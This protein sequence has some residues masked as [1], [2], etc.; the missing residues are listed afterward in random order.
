MF[1]YCTI[2]AFKCGT[3]V[4]IISDSKPSA[5]H[6]VIELESAGF[7]AVAVQYFSNLPPSQVS[8]NYITHSIRS[9]SEINQNPL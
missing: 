2:L 3:P 7:S 8:S 5:A 6:P 9:L 1:L 4:V